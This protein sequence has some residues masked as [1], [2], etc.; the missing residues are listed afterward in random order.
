M[1]LMIMELCTGEAAFLPFIP[2]CTRFSSPPSSL[3]LSFELA[4]L[5]SFELAPLWLRT[6]VPVYMVTPLSLP[7]SLSMSAVPQ[8]ETGPTGSAF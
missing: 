1:L 8:H 5:L 2:P 3:H 7:H 4:L 6:P